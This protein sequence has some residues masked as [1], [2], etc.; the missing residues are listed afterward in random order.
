MKTRKKIKVR[1]IPEWEPDSIQALADQIRQSL[2][3]PPASDPALG[4]DVEASSSEQDFEWKPA[5]KP[6]PEPVC[7]CGHAK[8]EHRYCSKRNPTACFVRLPPNDDYCAC[9]EFTPAR[10]PQQADD[11]PCP[12]C[13]EP[14]KG[15]HYHAE[16]FTTTSQPEPDGDRDQQSAAYCSA[17]REKY[18]DLPEDQWRAG[19]GLD[20]F[21]AGWEARPLPIPPCPCHNYG[22]HYNDDCAC[23]YCK[24]HRDGYEAGE[25]AM[26]EAWL[27]NVANGLY[28]RVPS[29][30]EAKQIA[31]Q[32]ALDHTMKWDETKS[33]YLCSMCGELTPMGGLSRSSAYHAA[34]V[35]LTNSFESTGEDSKKT[36]ETVETPKADEPITEAFEKC[37]NCDHIYMF[38]DRGGRCENEHFHGTKCDCQQFLPKLAPMCGPA[39]DG[40]K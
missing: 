5:D 31:W 40:A 27:H 35:A 37:Q 29:P 9:M 11:P 4:P 8:S 19:V 1:I 26:D 24:G 20:G 21:L 10:Q 7:W 30:D 25:T 18:G 39:K 32:F 34:Y 6:T 14:E 16:M 3:S 2:M 28:R 15:D 13:V 33:N 36:A 17:L 38:H 23:H 12:A 22:T